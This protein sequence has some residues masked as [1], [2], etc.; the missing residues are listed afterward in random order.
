MEGIRRHLGFSTE[1]LDAMFPK[2]EDLIELNGN[3]LRDMKK[4]QE[5][6]P[7]YCVNRIGN[8]ILKHVS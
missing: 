3:F 1:V 4:E 7:N 2:L 5:N 8:I 6:S